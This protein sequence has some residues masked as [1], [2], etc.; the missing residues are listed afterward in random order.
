LYASFCNRMRV[1]FEGGSFPFEFFLGALDLGF[2]LLPLEWQF[3]W[4]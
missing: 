2:P 1:A 4:F 3:F